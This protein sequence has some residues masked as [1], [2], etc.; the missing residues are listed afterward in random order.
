MRGPKEN[1]GSYRFSTALSVVC[2]EM[3]CPLKP[4]QIEC[5]AFSCDHAPG[6]SPDFTDTYEK[7]YNGF[8]GVS[9]HEESF[10]TNT[11]WRLSL[12]HARPSWGS[13]LL[14][15]SFKLLCVLKARLFFSMLWSYY[16][17][18]IKQ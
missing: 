6:L 16:L 5:W 18:S 4:A 13:L 10:R 7:P 1:D 3:T 8:G 12:S 17:R 15:K 14:D 9:C 2:S 11:S